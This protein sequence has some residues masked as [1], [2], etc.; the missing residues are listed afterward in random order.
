MTITIPDNY[1]FENVP[2]SKK[3]RTDDN[4]LIYS[5]IVTQEGNSLTVETTVKVDD[6]VFPKEYYPA[7]TQIYDN[8]TKME[9]QVVTA[10]K[11]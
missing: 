3:F 6:S 8:I 1:V 2:K 10:V 4:A 7:I 5:Y 11:K 9:A